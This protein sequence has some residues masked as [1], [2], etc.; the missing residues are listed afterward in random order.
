MQIVNTINQNFR[1]D[2]QQVFIDAVKIYG[3][4]NQLEQVQE[5]LSELLLAIS[6]YKRTLRTKQGEEYTT[7]AREQM[8][9]EVADVIIMMTQMKLLFDNHNIQDTIAEK[10]ERQRQ[11]MAA[12][13]QNL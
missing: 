4:V 7:V 3:E 13:N 9:R 2:E 1:L 5:E 8:E 11:R 6:K 12:K 10:L